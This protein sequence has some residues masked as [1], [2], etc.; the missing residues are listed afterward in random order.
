MSSPLHRRIG[1]CTVLGL[2][3][4]PALGAN[5]DKPKNQS[6][7]G[8]VV[9]LAKLLEKQGAKL[10]ADAAPLWLALV[11]D[12][13]KT[14]PLVKDDGSREHQYAIIAVGAQGRRTKSSPASRSQGLAT[15]RWDSVPGADSY[16]VVRDGKEL[17]GPIRI[18]G[19]RKDWTYRADP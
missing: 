18:E 11:T 10:D 8:K 19:S 15:L 1:L 3:L 5:A 9:P 4:S 17:A 2:C 13:G 12:D 6:Y 16:L 7:K 14:Y